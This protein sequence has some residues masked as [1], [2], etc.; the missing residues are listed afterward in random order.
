MTLRFSASSAARLMACPASA[1]LELAIPGYK[2]PVVDEMAGAKG[3]GSLV[4]ELL[5]ASSFLSAK[6]LQHLADILTYVSQLRSRRR[7]KVLAEE[8]VTADWLV[9][10]PKTTADLVLY[11]QDEIHVIDYKWG[12]IP[13]ELHDNAQL[14]FYAACYAK[15]APKATGVTVHVLQPRADTMDSVFITATQLRAFM[16]KAKAAD[17]KIIDGD[18]TFGPSDHCLFC[19]AYPHSRGDKGSPLCPTTLRMLYPPKVDEDEILG[20]T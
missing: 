10:A 7:F 9:S 18:L 15:L 1:N 2:P 14:L 20:L 11:V 8:T 17:Q 19:P 5:E 13:V 6:E 3:R 12:L 16:A 4:H